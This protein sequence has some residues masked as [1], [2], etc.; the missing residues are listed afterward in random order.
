[1]VIETLRRRF[2]PCVSLRPVRL[3]NQY[4]YYIRQETPT[5]VGSLSEESSTTRLL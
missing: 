2:V 1:M 5:S 4:N 3:R